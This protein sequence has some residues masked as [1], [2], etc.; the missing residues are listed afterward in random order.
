MLK[1]EC[2]DTN[3]ISVISLGYYVPLHGPTDK[4]Y[5]TIVVCQVCHIDMSNPIQKI[6]MY[7]AQNKHVVS[8][9]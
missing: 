4:S 7:R 5:M 2:R 1:H 6:A 8:L 9:T 3:V